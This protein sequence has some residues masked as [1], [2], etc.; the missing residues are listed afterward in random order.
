MKTFAERTDEAVSAELDPYFTGDELS[1]FKAGITWLLT[2]MGLSDV[3]DPIA[4]VKKMREALR[5]TLNYLNHSADDLVGDDCIGDGKRT[6]RY[7][8]QISEIELALALLE[9]K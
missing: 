4:A 1:A 7:K 3:E 6:H 5:T 8:R 2:E 9:K